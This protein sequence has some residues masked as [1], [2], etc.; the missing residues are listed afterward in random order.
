MNQQQTTLLNFNS[1]SFDNNTMTTSQIQPRKVARL[2]DVG[3]GGN[4]TEIQ[5]FTNGSVGLTPF[6]V[7]Q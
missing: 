2:M 3:I 1:Q 6:D 5:H 4:E 7:N